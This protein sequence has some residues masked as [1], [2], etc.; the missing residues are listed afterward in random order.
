[1][2]GDSRHQPLHHLGPVDNAWQHHADPNYC[3]CPP[4]KLNLVNNA[5]WAG[6]VTKQ[7]DSARSS[8]LL[9]GQAVSHPPSTV[10]EPKT[11]YHKQRDRT[12]R[13]GTPPT[14]LFAL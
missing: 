2:R 12:G 3:S 1:M 4:G 11:A 5:D 9:V 14:P 6:D 8:R 7:F 10:H 13:S